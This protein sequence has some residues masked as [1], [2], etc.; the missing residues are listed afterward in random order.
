MLFGVSLLCHMYIMIISVLTPISVVCVFTFFCCCC[1][2]PRHNSYF[3]VYSTLIP[4]IIVKME[5][6]LLNFFIYFIIRWSV[7]FFPEN[8]QFKEKNILRACVF[9]NPFK[10]L[11]ARG[12]QVIINIHD[13]WVFYSILECMKNCCTNNHPPSPPPASSLSFRSCNWP[14]SSAHGCHRRQ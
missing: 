10:L 2:L 1:E 13:L 5:A 7:K 4:K 14:Q 12:R 11:Y 8:N 9:V 3:S 6:E